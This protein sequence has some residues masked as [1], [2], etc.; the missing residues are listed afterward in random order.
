MWEYGNKAAKFTNRYHDRIGE[1]FFTFID[2]SNYSG[3]IS[4]NK[5]ESE[6]LH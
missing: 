6:D 2:V 3:D 4:R 1:L 5:N